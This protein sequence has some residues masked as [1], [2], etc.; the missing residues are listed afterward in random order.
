MQE[1][2][3]AKLFDAKVTPASGAMWGQKG[4]VRSDRYL[5]ECKTTAKSRY[6][7]TTRTWEKIRSEALKDHDRIP[8]LCI[9]LNNCD[10]YV[11]FNPDDFPAPVGEYFVYPHVH[12]GCKSFTFRGYIY[13]DLP[14]LFS[15]APATAN[16]QNH[17]LMAMSIDNFKEFERK[18]EE[19][20]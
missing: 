14:I 10:R 3:V 15:L 2:S 16:V 1:K 6:L 17:I 12:G 13:D 4:D 11:V 18:C 19:C 7:I 9:D 5:V 8:L 20:P